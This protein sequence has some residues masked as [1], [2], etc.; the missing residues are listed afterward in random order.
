[1]LH[2]SISPSSNKTQPLPLTLAFH[3]VGDRHNGEASYSLRAT[4]L[5]ASS[6]RILYQVNRGWAFHQVRDREVKNFIWKNITCHFEVPKAIVTDNGS[7]FIIFEFQDFCK[8][9]GIKLNFSTP[10]YHQANGQAES[11]N[12]TIIKTLKKRLKKAKGLWA[13]ELPSVHWSYRTT[14]QTPTRE[15][16]LSLAY[17]SE[18]VIRVKAGIPSARYQWLNEDTN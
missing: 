1:M 14:A 5:H 4:S 16:P 11:S 3:E 10:C 15:T 2:T 17:S 13:D 12:I 18:V 8:E 6:H 7:Q 9:W